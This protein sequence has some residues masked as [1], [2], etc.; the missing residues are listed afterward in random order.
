M[1]LEGVGL[2]SGIEGGSEGGVKEKKMR[3]EEIEKKR[4]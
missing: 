4:A 3:K 2:F 1:E